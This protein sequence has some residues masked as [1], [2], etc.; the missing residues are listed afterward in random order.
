[1]L[2]KRQQLVEIQEKLGVIF[3][4]VELLETAFTHRSF[5]NENRNTG[6]KHNERLEFLGDNVLGLATAQFLYKT[7]PDTP[8]G[9]LTDI[10]SV[11]V[12]GKMLTEIS[13][14]LGIDKFVLMSRGE[15]S[16]FDN[17][18]RSRIAIMEDVFEAILGA[19]Y[20]DRGIGI[21]ELFL[22]TTLF[23]KLKDVISRRLHYTPKSVLQEN[24]QKAMSITPHYVVKK[25]VGGQHN[26]T[27]FVAVYAGEKQL[28]V[29]EGKSKKLAEIDAV[30]KAL[31]SEFQ[32]V[33][34]RL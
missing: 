20:L 28:A 30:Y 6:L 32:I 11:M 31:E 18:A 27:F 25:T 10:Q 14:S 1:M 23:P 34:E 26:P 17:R 15:K 5:L 8:E 29:G 22:E 21:V 13:E 19:I 3:R 4:N 12:S 2:F 9:V 33:L 7:L 16:E 24:A